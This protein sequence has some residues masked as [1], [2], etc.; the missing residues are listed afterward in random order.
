MNGFKVIRCYC[1]NLSKENV[2]REKQLRNSKGDLEGETVKDGLV[3]KVE[4]KLEE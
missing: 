4:R 2:R 3:R 1:S